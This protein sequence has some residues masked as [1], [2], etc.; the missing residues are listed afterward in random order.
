MKKPKKSEKSQK[1]R[2]SSGQEVT[3]VEQVRQDVT[4]DVYPY[5]RNLPAVGP[6]LAA[7]PLKSL[8]LVSLFS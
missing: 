5:L 2:S 8:P 6:S 3:E 7:G 4:V 1:R